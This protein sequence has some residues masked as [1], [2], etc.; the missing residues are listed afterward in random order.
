MELRAHAEGFDASRIESEAPAVIRVSSLLIPGC[1]LASFACGSGG[2]SGS[3]AA[4]S[5]SLSAQTTAAATPTTGA[6][7]LAI[8]DQIL[9]AQI[10]CTT[11]LSLRPCGMVAAEDTV[12]CFLMCETQIATGAMNL[13]TKGALACAGYPADPGDAGS[14]ACEFVVPDDSPVHPEDMR[15]ACNSKCLELRSDASVASP[16]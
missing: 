11:T 3:G 12:N 8:S 7:A 4:S 14:P 1:A 5:A 6:P 9:E 2:V 15:V 13:V 10:L 16:N